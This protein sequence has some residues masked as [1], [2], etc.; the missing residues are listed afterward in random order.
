MISIL[1]SGMVSAIFASS[2]RL[3]PFLSSESIRLGSVA[4][5][6][7]YAILSQSANLNRLFNRLRLEI[8]SWQ[9][10]NQALRDGPTGEL[11]EISEQLFSLTRGTS[12]ESY[13]AGRP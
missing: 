2:I 13:R 4:F 3:Y 10:K 6:G 8:R 5:R 7:F 12:S 11:C 9:T 1:F